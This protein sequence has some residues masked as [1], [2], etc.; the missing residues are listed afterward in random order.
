VTD[1]YNVALKRS[2]E[3]ELKAL[4]QRDLKKVTDRLSA[5]ALQPRP[6]GCEKMSGEER[7]RLRQGDW[8]IIYSIDDGERTVTI[9]RIGHRREV[10][11]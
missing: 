7:Y 5:L 10:Y 1:V 2:A 3:K 9:Y 11:R 6:H 8:R 4:P